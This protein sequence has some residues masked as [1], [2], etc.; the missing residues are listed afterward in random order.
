MVREVFYMLFERSRTKKEREIDLK[1][2]MEYFNFRSKIQVDQHL[3]LLICS[4]QSVLTF[5]TAFPF[6]RRQ[7]RIRD[8]I[9]C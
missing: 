4:T 7:R 9:A 1:Q 8:S 6:L 5:R 2:P 3:E